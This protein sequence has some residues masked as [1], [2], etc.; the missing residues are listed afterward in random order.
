MKRKNFKFICAI[1]SVFMLVSATISVWAIDG[2]VIS[3]GFVFTGELAVDEYGFDMHDHVEGF[4]GIEPMTIPNCVN[5]HD[6]Y[7]FAVLNAGTTIFTA[8]K[9]GCRVERQGYTNVIKCHRET[10]G[11][12]YMNQYTYYEE[13]VLQQHRW[14]SN[15][16]CLNCGY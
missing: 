11:C 7:L 14:G 3:D 12:S 10:I 6:T 16:F 1:I 4:V 9:E 13:K 8:V 2:D 5:G 15:G